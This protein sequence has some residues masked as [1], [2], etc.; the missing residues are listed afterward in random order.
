MKMGSDAGVSPSEPLWTTCSGG[1]LV[2]K[3]HHTVLLDAYQRE[4]LQN[5]ENLENVD[6]FDNSDKH[7]NSA[8]RLRS[9]K[10]RAAL[11]M[12][13]DGKCC[14]CHCELPSDWHADHVVPWSVTHRTNVHEMQPLC[15]KCNIKKGRNERSSL[16]ELTAQQQVHSSVVPAATHRDPEE[17]Q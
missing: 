2:A 1:V 4:T 15:P 5:L 17:H 16:P 6:N 14:Q 10:L 8:R 9:K 11:W 3:S 12:G 13:A 7:R